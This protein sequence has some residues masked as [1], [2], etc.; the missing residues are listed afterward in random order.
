MLNKKN[1]LRLI[2]LFVTVGLLVTTLFISNDDLLGLVVY[3]IFAVLVVYYFVRFLK[4]YK[5]IENDLG[6]GKSEVTNGSEK[7]SSK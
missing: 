6:F 5:N 1:K 7:E 3:S 4:D 2:P